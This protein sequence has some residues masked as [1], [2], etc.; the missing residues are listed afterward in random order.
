MWGTLESEKEVTAVIYNCVLLKRLEYIGERNSHI[1]P[2]SA[3][4]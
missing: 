4:Y 2:P 1:R 3:T